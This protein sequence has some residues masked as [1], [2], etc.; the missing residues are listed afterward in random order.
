MQM[1]KKI[2]ILG[3]IANP[4]VGDE[5]I[6]C[7]NLKLI[8]NIYGSNCKVYIFSKKA[9][10]TALYSMIPGIQIIPVDY[11]HQLS[12]KEKYDKQKMKELSEK[13]LNET[14][15]N[16]D[17]IKA[18]KKIF[19]DIDVLHIIGGGYANSM[20]PDMLYEVY[21]ATLFARKYEKKYL[22]TGCSFFPT[23]DDEIEIINEICEYA[24]IVDL[25]DTESTKFIREENCQV[26]TDDAIYLEDIYP[27]YRNEKYAN[28]LIHKWNNNDEVLSEVRCEIIKFIEYCLNKQIV[29]YFNIL[30]FSEGDFDIWQDS[31]IFQNESVRKLSLVTSN[32]MWNKHVISNAQFNI[33]TRYHMAVFA[34]S[35]NTPMLSLYGKDQYYKNKI[36][37]IH[38]LYQSKSYLE[39]KNCTFDIILK[40]LKSIK[41]NNCSIKIL[42][43]IKEKYNKKCMGIAETYAVDKREANQ[44][45]DILIDNKKRPKVSIIIPIYNMDSFLR[46][47]LDSVLNQTLKEIEVICINDGSTDYTQTI[48][49]EYAW[50]DS[51]IV[52]LIQNNHGVAYARN[53]GIRKAT[54]EYLYFLDPDDWIPEKDTLSYMYDIAKRNKAL[55]VGGGFKECNPQGTI[56]EWSGDLCKYSFKE[57]GFVNYRDYQFDYGWTRFI[58]DRKLIVYNNLEIPQYKFFED[59]VFFV[60]VLHTAKKFYAITRCTYCYRTGHKSAELSYE[61]TVDLTKGLY[62]NIRFAI[63]NDYEELLALELN[64]LENDYGYIISKYLLKED[65]IQLRKNLNKINVLINEN[66]NRIE[67]IIYNRIIQNKEYEIW[68]SNENYNMMIQK[69]EEEIMQLRK[70]LEREYRS[71][72]WKIG[73]FFLFIPK[74]IRK[75][76][77]QGGKK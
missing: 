1:Y 68:N 13:I 71:L 44:I 6:L 8:Q 42:E 77:K 74:K 24:N 57:D 66:E 63:D 40:F 69:K 23:Y 33:G 36:K 53:R 22:L 39:L 49:D 73:D 29:E 67:Y 3:S 55:I 14:I 28:I 51:R 41:N 62:D 18:I 75:K 64:R 59:P 45:I 50:K 46:E 38:E 26:T 52:N 32:S 5:A 56:T 21:I 27:K 20:W 47:C 70:T 12:I 54:G 61:K 15:D 9:S 37:S 43:E 10:F 65:S 35:T 11:L 76:L 30:E 58:Y 2:A 16:D 25:R 34:L 60:R 31:S 4:N 72:T 7:S 19:E 17:S 48:L